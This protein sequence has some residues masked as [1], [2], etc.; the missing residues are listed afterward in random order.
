M[1]GGGAERDPPLN[2][3]Q[4]RRASLAR[5]KISTRMDIVDP[6]HRPAH[7]TGGPLALVQ[8]RRCR[9]QPDPVAWRRVGEMAA[10]RD[11]HSP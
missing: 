6:R 8:R 2:G 4:G 1:N 5:T 11:G 7:V 9:R 10:G 3:M